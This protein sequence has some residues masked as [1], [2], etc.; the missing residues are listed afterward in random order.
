MPVFE[1]RALNEKGKR[2]SGIVD[3][4]SPVAAR[5]KLRTSQIFPISINEISR[6]SDVTH[7]RSVSFLLSLF[8]RIRISE[9]SITTRGLA[10]LLSA[11][12]PLVAAL[13]TLIS[14]TKAPALKKALAKVKDLVVEGNSFAFALSQFPGAFSPLYINMAQAGEASGT[15]E[16]VLERLADM[17]ENQL[18]LNN[19]IRNALAYPL[20]M[21]LLGTAVLFF[22]MTVIVPNIAAVFAEMGRV[23]PAPTRLLIA[24][25]NLIQSFWWLIL[26]LCFSGIMVFFRVKKSPHGRDFIDRMILRIPLI[27]FL[28]IRLSTARFARTLCSLLENGVPMLQALDIVQN[29]VGYTPISKA[30]KA[31][32]KEI[33]KGS[34]LAEALASHGVFPNLFMQMLKV[35]EQSGKLEAMLKK[36]ASIYEKEVTA[37]VTRMTSLLEPIMILVMGVI[38]GGIVLSICL[39]IF[40]MNQLVF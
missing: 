21:T 22:L 17:M 7:P 13:E 25:S 31:G 1:Y 26:I 28:V 39:P 23:L 40:E 11:G 10:T 4:E 27:G 34:G 29:I 30:I 8:G 14:Q 24:A 2:V 33:E 15:L 18:D 36:T 6:L 38:V 5:Q 12:F 35:G 3:A 20:F 16:I 19:R 9:I 32:T 37:Q